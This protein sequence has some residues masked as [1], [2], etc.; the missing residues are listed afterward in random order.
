MTISILAVDDEESILDLMEAR[1]AAE[2]YRVARAL[3]VKAANRLIATNDFDIAI[4]DIGLPDGDGLELVRKI[5]NSSRCGIIVVSGRGEMTDRILGLEI[6]ADDYIVKP[7]HF[8][9]LIAR[10]RA[11][12]RRLSVA[13][14]T[15]IPEPDSAQRFGEYEINFLTRQVRRDDGVEIHLTSREFDVLWLL[16]A[17]SPRVL[18]RD[19]IIEAAFGG[20]KT[21]GGKPVDVIVS[22]LRDKLFG[23][24]PDRQRIRTVAGR[25]YQLI[26]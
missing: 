20:R 8:R 26:R 5:R 9:D 3:S 25:G 14:R 1:L 2:G 23:N 15:S 10:V 13:V 22:R 12:N 7:F 19:S 11:V 6:G 16:V 21:L 18:T 17:K 4:I 24:G